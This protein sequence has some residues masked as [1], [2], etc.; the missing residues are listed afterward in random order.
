MRL[1]RTSKLKLNLGGR[2]Y[3]MMSPAFQEIDA[4]NVQPCKLVLLPSQP[5]MFQPYQYFLAG[6]LYFITLNIGESR[7]QFSNI[8]YIQ[9][10]RLSEVPLYSH[11]VTI[12]TQLSLQYHHTINIPIMHDQPEISDISLLTV[13]DTKDPIITE[14]MFS[15]SIP[16][17]LNILN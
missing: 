2:Y 3:E 17:T 8:C 9:L 11:I 13:N 14:R 5:S 6:K 1:S 16:K 15:L 7:H 10:L 4:R 12:M